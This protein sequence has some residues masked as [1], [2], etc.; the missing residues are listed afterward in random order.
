M[1]LRAFKTSARHTEEVGDVQ[2]EVQ[3]SLVPLTLLSAH[4]SNTLRNGK[5]KRK[6][7]SIDLSS[8]NK[9]L[10][11][12]VEEMWVEVEPRMTF[13]DLCKVTLNYGLIPPVVPEFSSI[14][15][16]GAIMGAALESSSHR[17]GQV[18][19]TC[20][21]YEVIL[22]NGELVKCS[23]EK[24]ADLFY[25]LSGSYGTLALLTSIKLRL[26]KAERY[27][28]LTYHKYNSLSEAISFLSSPPSVDFIEGIAFSREHVV[29]ITGKMTAEAST[30]LFRTNHYFSPWYYQH[31]KKGAAEEWMLLEE[32]LFRLDRGAFWIG[33][34]LASAPLLLRVLLKLR[35]KNI[36]FR[37][38][39]PSDPSRLL[40]LFFGWAFSSKR[41]YKIWHAV[42][43]T[44]SE[45]LFFIHDFYVP[46]SN[47][48]EALQ[49][50]LD[51]TEIF[52]V[53]LCPIRGT[54]TGQFLSPNWGKEN[55]INMGFY[56]IPRSNDS[57]PDLTAKLEKAILHLGGRKMLYS[58]TYYDPSLFAEIYNEE[59]YTALRK[60][61]H[62][63]G[64]FPSLYDKVCSSLSNYNLF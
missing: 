44:I 23:P 2:K 25:A 4:P 10:K 64:S 24:E 28:H 5:Y 16:G 30:P 31:V 54:T 47:A 8:L 59:R 1:T 35:L 42:P 13:S 32:Y 17:F 9:V 29:I 50:F 21:E 26:I 15:V 45:Q 49:H 58:F 34:F 18:S 48:E 61:F 46:T 11:I 51:E 37:K 57:I 43:N 36:N 33:R 6:S 38:K 22:G 63:E 3:A 14:T 20:L 12:N 40:R 52:P 62:A 39:P 60:K 55:L 41:L 19:D 53:W 7:A 56:G 27:V